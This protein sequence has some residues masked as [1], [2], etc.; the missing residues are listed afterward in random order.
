MPVRKRIAARLVFLAVGSI[1]LPCAGCHTMSTWP[2]MSWLDKGDDSS[3]YAYAE[4]EVVFPDL[5]PPGA[6]VEP[7][8]VD[9]GTAGS[10][11]SF[12]NQTYPTTQTP[13]GPQVARQSGYADGSFGPGQIGDRGGSVAGNSQQGFYP[14]EYRG[15]SSVATNPGGYSSTYS[16]PAA[17]EYRTTTAPNINAPHYDGSHQG[18]SPTGPLPSTNGGLY[19]GSQLNGGQQGGYVPAVN[20]I[21][22]TTIRETQGGYTPVNT[23]PPYTSNPSTGTTNQIYPST[24]ATPVYRRPEPNFHP[25]GTTSYEGLEAL[26]PPSMH[27]GIPHPSSPVIPAGFEADSPSGEPWEATLPPTIPAPTPSHYHHMGESAAP[28]GE[29]KSHLSLASSVG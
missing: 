15:D 27:R 17:G 12:E 4:P 28:F 2:G 20:P 18:T 7:N 21:P 5:P 10:F 13:D 8:P 23:Q 16:P 22:A 11:V 9:N 6:A 19:N 14:P 3:R 1:A 29:I 25:A 24:G 26:N